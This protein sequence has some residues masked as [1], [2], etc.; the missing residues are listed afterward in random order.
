MMHEDV[1]NR[2]HETQVDQW[3]TDGRNIKRLADEH[4]RSG[5]DFIGC[6]LCL[7]GV[8]N[9]LPKWHH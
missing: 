7:K 9:G 1:R 4:L 3:E 5:V 6:H 2:R 8:W